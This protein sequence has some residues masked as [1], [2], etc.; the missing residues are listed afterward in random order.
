MGNKLKSKVMI[1]QPQRMAYAMQELRKRCI[2]PEQI[3]DVKIEFIWKGETISFWP[4]TG[5]ASGKSIEDGRGI[6]NLLKQIDN[7]EK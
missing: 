2:N 1:E 6:K 7:E 3:N 5:W 4:Y